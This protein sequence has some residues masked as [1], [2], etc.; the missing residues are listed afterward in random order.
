MLY[1][2]VLSRFSFSI[3]YCATQKTWPQC[4]P[5]SDWQHVGPIGHKNQS[6]YWLLYN[7][8][9]PNYPTDMISQ[10]TWWKW[11]SQVITHRISILNVCTVLL[12]SPKIYKP[13]KDSVQLWQSWPVYR[14]VPWA[15]GWSISQSGPPPSQ[16]GANWSMGWWDNHLSRG[17][18]SLY[19]N[20]SPWWGSRV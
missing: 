15:R 19:T 18:L 12:C 10:S 1:S 8:K 2:D 5:S 11:S 13:H 14:P 9:E 17:N 6:N 16:S 7:H 20:C 4:E 3:E